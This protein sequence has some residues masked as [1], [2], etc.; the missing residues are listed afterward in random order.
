MGTQK[1]MHVWP[2]K[3]SEKP[4]DTAS[5]TLM[6]EEIMKRTVGGGGTTTVTSGKKGS[7]HFSF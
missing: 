7:F 2:E 1:P 5:E 6:K 3:D 4:I